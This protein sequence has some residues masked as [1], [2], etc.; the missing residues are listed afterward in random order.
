[1][2]I[3]KDSGEAV[4]V[5]NYGY[6]GHNASQSTQA[7]LELLRLGH[8]PSVAIFMDGINV[9]PPFDGCE[10]SQGIADRFEYNET[11]TD[12]Y[13]A[14]YR[15]PFFKWLMPEKSIGQPSLEKKETIEL[16]LATDSANN[17]RYANRLIENAA[18]RKK[19]GELY[20]MQ[21][22]SFLQPNVFYDYN[23]SYTTPLFQKAFKPGIFA[24]YRAIYS[25]V[26]A[27]SQ[28]INLSNLFSEYG[29][30][31]VIDLL[32]YSPDFN[33]YLAEKISGCFAIDT[34]PP[35][36]WEEKEASNLSFDKDR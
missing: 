15:L 26:S 10:Y 25:T 22:I 23:R 7:F 27:S 2:K 31:A 17:R 5:K 1:M 34:M 14:I 8:R 32:H 20:G 6:C 36:K 12:V 28:Y 33:R 21:V 3:Y 4:L 13:K 29:Q 11:A 19:I 18:L 9:G 24:N 16:I 35:Y 30:P